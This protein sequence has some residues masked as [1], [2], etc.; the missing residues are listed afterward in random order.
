MARLR[1]PSCYAYPDLHQSRTFFSYV[2]AHCHV[3]AS[4]WNHVSGA[5]P[6]MAAWEAYPNQ[7]LKKVRRSP[8]AMANSVGVISRFVRRR[9]AFCF[10]L[11]SAGEPVPGDDTAMAR[12]LEPERLDQQF[13]HYC[14]IVIADHLR[15]LR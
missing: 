12:R 1:L 9:K 11:T 15:M 2:A 8:T 10:A 13:E 7:F 6:D 3:Q 14:L 5:V 4:S